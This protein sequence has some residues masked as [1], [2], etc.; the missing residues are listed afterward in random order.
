VQPGHGDAPVGEGPGLCDLHVLHRARH[1][2][3]D[4]A[5]V[6]DDPGRLVDLVRLDVAAPREQEPVGD[7]RDEEDLE[8][9]VGVG[10][11][12]A[13]AEKSSRVLEPRQRD[14]G[15]PGERARDHHGGRDDRRTHVAGCGHGSFLSQA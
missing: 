14:P 1:D 8:N 2:E 11:Q 9:Q 7:P 12:R 3:H 10:D 13:R 6:E 4:Q 5:D 15:D